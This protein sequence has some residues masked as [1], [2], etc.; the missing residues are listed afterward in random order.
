MINSN[1][2]FF[3]VLFFLIVGSARA[4]DIN[5]FLNELE[6]EENVT[7]T[8]NLIKNQP[9]NRFVDKVKLHGLNKISGKTSTLNGVIGESI[10]F[11]K[12]EISLLKCWKSY[13]EENTENK[14]LLKIFEVDGEK[15]ELIFYGWFFSSSPSVSGLEHPLYD[16]KLL[17]CEKI[18]D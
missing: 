2:K 1:I 5:S 17:D 8:K 6:N 15:K 10:Q 14:L 18:E 13:P 12:L 9:K 3:V 4:N 7:N 16:L 11:E